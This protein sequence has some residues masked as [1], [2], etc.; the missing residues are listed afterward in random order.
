MTRP[1]RCLILPVVLLLALAAC[2]EPPLYPT[3][4]RD[5]LQEQGVAEA[6]IERLVRRRPLAVAEVELL[7]GYDN[8]PVLH[9]LGANPATP[10]PLLRRL[11]AHS[12][13]EVRTGIAGN[14]R[15]PVDLL[16]GLRTKGK[17]T[18]VNEVLARNPRLPEDV[19]REMR[20][21][22]EA[23]D[24]GFAMNPALPEDLM[25]EIAGSDKELTR[26]WLARNPS[27]PDDVIGRLANDPAPFVRKGLERNPAYRRW[28]DQHSQ[29]S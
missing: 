13:F 28:R 20:R 9:L 2:N 17:Y 21:N 14:P 8:V 5:F 12:N 7:S 26:H 19:I 27:L 1:R 4:A 18:T 24:L 3:R 15:A 10:E 22:G 6:T 11:G 29:G 25:R 16:L 23:Q